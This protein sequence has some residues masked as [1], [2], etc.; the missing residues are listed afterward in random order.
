MVTEMVI[1]KGKVTLSKPQ[2]R[3]GTVKVRPYLFLNPALD[4]DNW[5]ISHSGP[6]YTREKS[7]DI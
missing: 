7:G 5:L 4:E 2:K 6:V 3:I 1:R